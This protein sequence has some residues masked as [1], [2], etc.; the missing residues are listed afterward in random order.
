MLWGFVV[1]RGDV[2]GFLRSHRWSLPDTSVGPNGQA[3]RPRCTVM[4]PHPVVGVMGGANVPEAV[5]TQA[6]ELGRRIAERGWVLLNGGRDEGVMRASAK[7]AASAEGVVLGVLPGASAAD[8][9]VAEDATYRVFT[10]LGDARN[11]VNVLSSDVVVACRGGMGTLSEVALAL[12]VGKPVVLLAWPDE[13]VPGHLP[14][15][16]VE[17]ASSAREAIEAVSQRLGA[18]SL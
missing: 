10:G 8:A 14:E 12:K 16:L 17:R 9:P 13:E 11:L 5:E 3:V 1:G 2:V 6:R 7:G 18:S 4:D 15:E